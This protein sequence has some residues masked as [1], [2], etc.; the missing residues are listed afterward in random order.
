VQ[1][2]H[3]DAFL[4]QIGNNVRRIRNQ[5]GL[6]M[7]TVANEAQIEYRQLGRIER[8]EVNATIISLLK[9]STVLKINLSQFF[10]QDN[11]QQPNTFT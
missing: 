1:Q 2:N 10:D 4:K 3:Y 8:G 7:E 6:T 5:K 9:I 11:S